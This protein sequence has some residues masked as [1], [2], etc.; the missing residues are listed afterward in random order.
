[1]KIFSALS[2]CCEYLLIVFCPTSKIL[3]EKDL[4]S[5]KEDMTKEIDQNWSSANSYKEVDFN[6]DKELGDVYKDFEVKTSVLEDKPLIK[7][8][9]I[10]SIKQGI[11]ESMTQ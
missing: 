4:I 11:Y 6:I 5:L 8:R 9:L 1:M 7:L 10:D 2:I 3:S